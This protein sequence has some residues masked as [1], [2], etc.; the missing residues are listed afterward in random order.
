MPTINANIAD[1]LKQI[2][3]LTNTNLQILKSL[4]D[5]FYTKKNHLYTEINDST[6]I[7]PSFL[8]LENKINMLQ[9]NFENLVKSPENCEAYFNFDGNTRAIEVR[10]YNYTPNSIKP[11]TLT[12]YSVE[13]NSIFKDFLTPVPY[14]NI[15]L[16]EIP[17]DITEVN[18]KKIVA[19]S[20]KLKNLFKNRLSYL[21]ETVNEAGE[22][23]TETR[24]YQ[25]INDKYSSIYKF[26]YNYVNGTDYEEYDSIYK[27]PT[28]K[29]IGSSSY[30]IERVISDIIDDDLNELITLK[31]RSDIDDPQYNNKLTY[32]LFDETIEKQLQVGDELV[33]YDGTGKVVITNITPSTNTM[34]VKIV[35]GEYLNFLG[36]DTYDTNNDTN[37][38]NLSKLRF[39]AAID[40]ND[41]KYVKI[42][43]EEDQYIFVAIA[44][45][46][47]KLNVQSSWGTGIIID[48]HSLIN[49]KNDVDFKTYYDENVKNI[50]DVLFEMTS[51]ITSP[52]MALSTTDFNGLTT[53]KPTLKEN[54]LVVMQINKH[55]NN[56]TSV[57]NIRQAYQQK[58]S[59]ELQLEQ[60]QVKINDINEKI[61]SNEFNDYDN[62]G[63]TYL[64]EL[65]TLTNQKKDLLN[66]INTAI[67]EISLNLNSSEIPTSN[68]KYRIRGFYVPNLNN[69]NNIVTNDHV[70]GIHVQY[71]YKN[72][73]SELGNAV[74]M[75]DNNSSEAF[76]YSDWNLLTT[77]K[78]NKIASIE[79]GNYVYSYE[80]NDEIINEPSYNQIDIPISQGETVD[81]RLKVI[82]D[83]GQPYISVTSD[84]SNILSISFPDEF[85]QTNSIQSIASE[86]ASDNE[87]IKMNSMLE[88][89]GINSHMTDK[90]IDQNITYYH[91]SENIASG[92]YTEERKV[93]P[94]KDKLMSLSND[95]AAIKD[96]TLNLT[97]KYEV[98]LSIGNNSKKL[99]TDRENIL[100][101]AAYNDFVNNIQHEY[102]NFENGIVYCN[103]KLSIKNVGENILKLYS[104]FPGRREVLINNSK[105][106]VVDKSPYCGGT[107]EGIIY[108]Y[109]GNDGNG[110]GIY[111]S[112]QTQ[113]QFITF[114]MNDLWDGTDYYKPNAVNSSNESNS[115]NINELS[116]ET[117][118]MVAYP[119]LNTKYGLCI[120]SDEVR[121]YKSL[122]PN[123]EVTIPIYCSFVAKTDNSQI[124]KTMSFD[125]RTN[126]HGDIDNY[127]FKI[128]GNNSS[129]IY[130]N[131]LTE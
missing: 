18:V 90:L 37:I 126:L 110:V 121:T 61:A 98:T 91:R 29:N 10:K 58:K 114:R 74:T 99:Y 19:K 40:L 111:E 49:I 119:L 95:I 83:F 101:L 54:D 88:T 86:I 64:T 102:Y 5:S 47:N 80:N 113:N 35:N 93:I 82:Y 56:A 8:S 45:I 43:L 117:V 87:S 84:W 94:L 97:P 39:Y 109:K 118:G 130:D 85:V 33:N 104:L 20:D 3:S 28:R 1:Y 22:A 67:S 50:G 96:Y 125:V 127:V 73:S 57:K 25:S 100:T 4:N 21:V 92:F 27:L 120:N 131:M 122:N 128:V 81:V 63:Q 7:I 23:I 105:C 71:R 103:A 123:E 72:I 115:L 60:L 76:I 48:T 55:L 106:Q 41:N 51:M 42:P 36:T 116:N 15:E 44:P 53:A 129:T 107:N 38:H 77:T 46:N 62:V 59:A 65:S 32:K 17:N 89:N 24:Y 66:I 6:Y 68:A 75:N 9:E 31:L 2:E 12:N 112:L 124:T 14:I 11:P 69:V 13:S 30:V 78:R 79:N 70:I 16:P 26:L 34:T 108:K 52:I